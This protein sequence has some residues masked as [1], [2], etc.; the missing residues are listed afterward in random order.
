[1]ELE[2]TT[3][4]GIFK[5]IKEYNI[6][7]ALQP[8]NY[9][10]GKSPV[11]LQCHDGTVQKNF[12]LLPSAFA[13]LDFERDKEGN[14]L[15]VVIRGGGYGHGVGMS[16]YGTYGLTLMGK[17]W[18]EITEHYYPG[19]QLKNIYKKETKGTDADK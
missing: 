19:S 4:Y 7:L 8:V 10:R 14:L 6:R 18:Q 13:C 12:S 16:Q 9:L 11:E 5:V 1:M 3:T 15:D 2:I 17:D